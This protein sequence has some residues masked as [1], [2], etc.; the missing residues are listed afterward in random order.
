V[1]KPLMKGKPADATIIIGTKKEQAPSY[2]AEVP[3][4]TRNR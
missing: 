1:I 2:R 4:S 3:R